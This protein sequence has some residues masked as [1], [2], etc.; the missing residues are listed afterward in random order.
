MNI[1]WKGSNPEAFL[2]KVEG[3]YF[4]ERFKD[5]KSSLETYVSIGEAEKA[6]N[7][8]SVIWK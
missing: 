5:R 3:G 2:L 6:Y 8:G 1:V 4:F 7:N